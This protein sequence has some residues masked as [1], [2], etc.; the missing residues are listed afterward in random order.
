MSC[1]RCPGGWRRLSPPNGQWN[2]PQQSLTQHLVQALGITGGFEEGA[3][4]THW[5]NS[6]DCLALPSGICEWEES[7]MA[8]MGF[9]HRTPPSRAEMGELEKWTE[10]EKLWSGFSELT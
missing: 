6:A 4:G 3:V 10:K 1:L 7:M 8:L 9:S 2:S 5:V